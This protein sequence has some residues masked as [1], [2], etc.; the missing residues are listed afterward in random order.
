ML[1]RISLSA[2]PMHETIELLSSF[3][4]KIDTW[5]VLLNLAMH[6]KFH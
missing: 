6:C 4:L 3:V 2:C 1:D 5:G